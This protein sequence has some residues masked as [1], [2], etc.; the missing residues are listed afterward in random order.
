M[1]LM[2]EYLIGMTLLNHIHTIFE[3]HGP[4]LSDVQYLLGSGQPR[5]M[6]ATCSNMEVI[7]NFFSFLMDK[8]MT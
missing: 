5:E 2:G 1:H 8:E 7:Q 3:D 4:K 6:T